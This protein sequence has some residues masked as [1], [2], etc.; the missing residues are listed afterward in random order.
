MS[1]WN[2]CWDLAY[3]IKALSKTM[4]IH[5][6]DTKNCEDVLIFF[7]IIKEQSERM[8]DALE[9]MELTLKRR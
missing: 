8:I 2:K 4:L 5:G 6:D 3:N 9:Q 1:D 7:R